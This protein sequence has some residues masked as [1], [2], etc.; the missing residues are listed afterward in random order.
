METHRD[1]TR[2]RQ[3]QADDA[4]D[5]GGGNSRKTQDTF[6]LRTLHGRIISIDFFRRNWWVV[7]GVVVMLMVYITNRYTCQTQMER[8]RTLE[9]ELEVAKTERVR[10]KSAYM[11]K[12]RESSIQEMVDSLGL[13]ITVQEQPPYRLSRK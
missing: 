12:I 3:A 8:I 4:I 2:R 13:G 1:D 7:L 11:S 10:A 5:A 9:R 6:L